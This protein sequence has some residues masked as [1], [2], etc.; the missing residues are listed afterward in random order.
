MWDY[1]KITG[2]LI[3]ALVIAVT[4]ILTLLGRFDI[5]ASIG[6]IWIW[7]AA[8]LLGYASNLLT[9][10]KPLKRELEVTEPVKPA[11]TPRYVE[12]GTP[13]IPKTGEPIILTSKLLAGIEFYPSRKELPSIESVIE[14]AKSSVDV[15]AFTVEH[16]ADEAGPIAKSVGDDVHVKHFRFILL[17]PASRFMKEAVELNKR[18]TIPNRISESLDKLQKIKNGLNDIQRSRLDIRIHDSLPIH[19]MIAVDAESD[20]GLIYVENYI[21]NS[22]PGQWATLRISKKEQDTLFQ[23][24]WQD[25]QYVRE[26]SKTWP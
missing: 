26:R 6:D 1:R 17:S 10:P 23:K 5:M 2:C 15:L 16:W 14:T 25:Y 19:S 22:A 13:I 24:Y 12:S 18:T 4:I 9:K 7:V 21:H 11:L 8:V 3:V 20:S